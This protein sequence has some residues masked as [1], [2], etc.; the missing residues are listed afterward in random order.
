MTENLNY[1]QKRLEE[2][3][4]SLAQARRSQGLPVFALEHGLDQRQLTLITSLLHAGLRGAGRLGDHWLVWI[5]YAAEQGYNYDGAEYW[6]SFESRTPYWAERADR[7]LL[8][9]WFNRFHEKYAGLEPTG[10]WAEWFSIIA[11]PIT[12]AL[13]PKD[14]QIQ[15]ARALYVLRYALST[16]IN[17]TPAAIGRYVARSSNEGSS[18]FRNFL[19]QEEIAGRIILALLGGRADEVQQSIHPLT[20]ERIVN[21][22]Q[23][24]RNARE[25]LRDARRA[26]ESVQIKGTSRSP[27]TGRPAGSHAAPT[28]K[29][30]TLAISPHLML[31]R[32]AE[33]EWTAV[34]EVPCFRD[35]ADLAPEISQFL[36]QKRCS[37]A[38]SVGSLPAGWLL[39]GQQRR[40][41]SSWPPTDRP[42]IRFEQ[43]NPALEH[44]LQSEVRLTTGPRWLFCIGSDGLAREIVG[45]VVRPGMSYILA[46]K[47]SLPAL[48]LSKPTTIKCEG[49]VA[50]R[51]DLPG[52]LDDKQMAELRS[53]GLAIAQTVRIWPVGLGARSWDGEGFSEWLEGEAPCFA[54]EHD[55]PVKA[56]EVQLD[57]QPKL[58]VPA[59]R[60]GEPVL[61]R[62]PPLPLGKH[63]LLVRAV[64]IGGTAGQSHP[65]TT[66]GY[67]SLWVRAPR[68]WISGTIGHT[69]LV[70][71]ADPSDTSIDQFWEGEARLQVLG[72][73]GRPVSV[74]VELLDSGGGKLTTEAIAGMT[75]PVTRESW[76]RA[77]SAFLRKDRDPWAFL[78]ASSGNVIIE[79]DELGAYRVPLHRPAAP[80][81]WVWHRTHRATELR[82]VDDHQGDDQLV[83]RFFPFAH[84]ASPIDLDA[85]CL[86]S[87]Y[88]PPAPGGLCVA[89][90]GAQKQAL[91]VSVPAKDRGLGGLLIEP[92]IG[93]LPESD[94]AV[95]SILDFVEL[96]ST[97][98]LTGPL[99]A[100]RRSRVVRGLRQHVFRILCGDRWSTAET[101][102]LNSSRT[103]ADLRRLGQYVGGP[104]AFAS[105]LVRDAS[106]LRKMNFAACLQQF[107]SLAH[108]YG[109]SRGNECKVALEFC[110]SV[111]RGILWDRATTDSYIADMRRSLAAIRGARLLTL[112]WSDSRES[113]EKAT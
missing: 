58:Q 55:H 79:N 87:G 73:I 3:F 44:L 25:W 53:A 112:A 14:L 104:P 101:C 65:L 109:I 18:R 56:F 90:Y 34:L 26:V 69:G 75:L 6:A 81:R 94:G 19:E 16:R 83:A 54:L 86:A 107:V 40:V 5:V 48:P 91:V 64:G 99:A 84:P 52:R 106:D 22:L 57:N 37:V 11:W 24:I 41:L 59:A 7:R 51:F 92:V 45:R 38:G 30:P 110:Q 20:L 36:R 74:R 15:L 61:V 89:N 70:V 8:R 80:L 1:W 23:Q 88:N 39:S 62:L 93:N 85:T 78:A 68:P 105:V 27:E 12:H 113:G 100:E 50:L 2:H 43:N 96:W 103:D 49:I 111:T 31:R 17:D 28:S 46:S 35:V 97:A 82:L 98:R 4:A 47:S 42:L 13:L 108:R 95:K 71:T 21:D 33:D 67:V 10:T 32:T 76:E 63:T 77:Q 60:P 29:A 66:D 102:Y 72:P 9:N